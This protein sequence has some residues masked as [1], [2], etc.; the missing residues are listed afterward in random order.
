[1]R[2][3]YQTQNALYINVAESG[4]SCIIKGNDEGNVAWT[5][6]LLTEMDEAADDIKSRFQSEAIN[7]KEKINE[8]A[9]RIREE[10]DNV[11]GK[12]KEKAIDEAKRVKE[13]ESNVHS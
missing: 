2:A 1:M 3:T 6:Q 5:L 13:S 10:S 9:N 4:F 7:I 12:I 8:N 11:A